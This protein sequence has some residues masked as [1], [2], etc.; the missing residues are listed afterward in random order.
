M[1]EEERMREKKQGVKADVVFCSIAVTSLAGA[2]QL[3]WNWEGT[4]HPFRASMHYVRTLEV[5]MKVHRY[6]HTCLSN[7]FHWFI[8]ASIGHG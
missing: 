2:S 8:R 1:Y 5:A 6:L 7:V 4:I 3:C